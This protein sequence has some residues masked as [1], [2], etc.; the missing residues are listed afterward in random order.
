MKRPTGGTGYV[1]SSY[2]AYTN[3][4][5]GGGD[6]VTTEV[7]E[8]ADQGSKARG[9]VHPSKKTDFLFQDYREPV[10]VVYTDPSRLTGRK[11]LT[12][13]VPCLPPPPQ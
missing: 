7:Q 8:R 6:M 12:A 2:G 3:T 1:P 5:K 11:S 4:R 10:K 9:S 13:A